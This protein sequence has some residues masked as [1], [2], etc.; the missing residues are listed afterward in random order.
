MIRVVNLDLMGIF[1]EG[2]VEEDY[3]L[4]V[5]VRFCSSLAGVRVGMM[6]W[7]SVC[8]AC[9]WGDVTW[10]R[11]GN[12]NSIYRMIQSPRSVSFRSLNG[13]WPISKNKGTPRLL[14]L[15]N[16]L[17]MVTH[18]RSMFADTSYLTFSSKP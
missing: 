11:V 10:N 12:K 17:T 9:L 8:G 5:S 18:C 3:R 16:Q 13:Q 15:Q 6:T 4:V 7:E 1:L 2:V 14:V